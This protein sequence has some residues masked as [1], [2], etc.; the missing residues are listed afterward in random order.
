MPRG[1]SRTISSATGYIAGETIP[2]YTRDA[3]L[4]AEMIPLARLFGAHSN[5]AC[6]QHMASG[7]AVVCDDVDTLVVAQGQASV[8]DLERSL[9]DWSGELHVIGDGLTPRTV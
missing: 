3:W 4:G 8:T 6:F 7:E 5:S 2:R 1:W 9:E